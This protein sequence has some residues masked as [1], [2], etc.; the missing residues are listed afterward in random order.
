[1]LAESYL[2]KRGITCDLPPDLRF[3]DK[4]PHPSGKTFCPRWLLLLK[5][6]GF[7]AIHRIFL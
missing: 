1:M 5:G 4:C 2:R 3:H 7:F 6:L